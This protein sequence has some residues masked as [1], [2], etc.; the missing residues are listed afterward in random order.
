MLKI[1]MMIFIVGLIGSI[2]YGAYATWNHMQAK[3]EILTANNAKLEGAVQTQK[4]TIG[5]LESD[6]QA[7]NTELNAVNKQMTRTRTRNKILAKK[8][9]SLD[10]GLLGVEKPDVAERIINR[11]T[12]N[13]GRCF[14]LMSGAPLS[15]KERDAENGKAFNRECPW[16]FD[17]L[18]IPNRVQQPEETTP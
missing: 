9:E 7:V 13:A 11:G 1:Y 2:G 3:I 17:T 16:L 18:V 14:E 12:V 10:L 15:E 8:L 5:A 4:D 6:I